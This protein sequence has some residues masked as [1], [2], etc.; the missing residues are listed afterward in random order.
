MGRSDAPWAQ[1]QIANDLDTPVRVET[2]EDGRSRTDIALPD[3]YQVADPPRPQVS[4]GVG[5]GPYLP[6]EPVSISVVVG[7]THADEYGQV[8][9]QLPTALGD[10]AV[11]VHGETSGTTRPLDTSPLPEPSADPVEAP[12][13]RAFMGRNFDVRRRQP[14]SDHPRPARRAPATA[15]RATADDGLGAL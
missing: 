10:R 11:L 14:G 5:A 7:Q 12:S 13:R 6:G 9:Y 3:S 4:D 15:S 8:R 2:V 1:Q